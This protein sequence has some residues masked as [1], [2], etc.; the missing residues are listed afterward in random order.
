MVEFMEKHMVDCPVC[1]ADPDVRYEVRKIT[2]IVLPPSKM[3]K[4]VKKAVSV[5][6]GPPP[7]INGSVNGS[8]AENGGDQ[9]V[10]AIQ[11]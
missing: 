9:P 6:D 1:Q 2:E 11:G 5:P 7:T 10:A 8:A 4:V 3:T